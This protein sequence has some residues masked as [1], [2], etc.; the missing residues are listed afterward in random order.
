MKVIGNLTKDAIIRAAVSEGFTVSSS[1]G[2]GVVY[3]AAGTGSTAI[4]FDTHNGKVIVAYQDQGNSNYGTAIVGTVSGTS[5]SFGTAVVYESANIHSQ[6]IVFDSSNNKVVIFYADAGNSDYGTAVVGTVSGTSISFGTP[7]VFASVGVS[8]ISADFDT[9]ANKIVIAYSQSGGKAI[10]GTVSGT[11]ISFGS[12][13]LFESGST[14]NTATVYDTNANKTVIAYRDNGDGNKGKAIVGTVSGTSISYG[15]IVNMDTENTRDIMASYDP[16]AQKILFVYK[17]LSSPNPGYS[18][19]GTVSGTSIS[20]GTRAEYHAGSTDVNRVVYDVNAAKHVILFRD[21]DHSPYR[22]KIIEATVSGT[23]VSYSDEL[24]WSSTSFSEPAITYDPDQKKVVFAYIDAN[25]SYYGTA[26]VYTTSLTSATGG[27]IADGKAVIVNAN[28]TVSTVGQTA[29]SVG[30]AVVYESANTGEQKV[31]FDSTNNKIVINYR[32]VGNSSY[33]T[34][35]VGTVS[36]DS[37]SFG[38]PVVFESSATDYN[39]I[40]FDSST[41]KVVVIFSTSATGQARVGTVSGTSI[42]FGGSVVFDSGQGV[43]MALAYDSS[44]SKVVVGYAGTNNYLETKVGT[45]SGTSISFGT[46]VVAYSS[47]FESLCA[48]FDSN[49]NKVVFGWKKNATGRAVVGTVSGTSISYGSS[50]AYESSSAAILQ[51]ATFDTTNNK[52]VIAYRASSASDAGRAVVGTVSGTDITF[53]TAVQFAATNSEQLGITFDSSVGKVIIAYDDGDTSKGTVVSGTVSGTSITFDSAFV[54]EDASVE[55]VTAVFDSNANKTVIA[56]KDAGNSNYGTGIV[57]TPLQS[58]LTSENFVG[59]MKGAALDGT[60]GEI[61]SSCSIARNQTSLTPGQ[62]YFV[63]PT[64]G[65]LSTSAGS[66]SVTAGTAI[67][68]TEIIVKG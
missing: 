48:T 38:T 28:G 37:I 22:G 33:G 2:S 12:A 23:S 68:S 67:S 44:N 3:E 45:V 59:F 58:N 13:A 20:F 17:I 42:S 19:V 41:G 43:Y 7:V 31:A 56:Y 14:Y 50:V 65:A 21:Q 40:V 24:Q 62:T 51:D 10:V 61:L 36:G 57:F 9:T 30:A 34:A 60:N 53:G 35:V 15:S 55:K 5:I 16:V 49:S 25:N 1:V 4:G 63:S 11:S 32:D 26:K 18:I 6:R 8:H 52:V 27:T 46:A 66:P 47:S 39:D 54:Y 29:A 64:D